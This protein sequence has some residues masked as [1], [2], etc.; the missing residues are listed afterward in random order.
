MAKDSCPAQYIISCSAPLVLLFS[1]IVL[2][3]FLSTRRADTTSRVLPDDAP[4]MASFAVER[5]PLP[6]D[7]VAEA[8]KV[9]TWLRSGAADFQIV[10]QIS[11]CKNVNGLFSATSRLSELFE[12][13]IKNHLPAGH[14]RP[15]QTRVIAIHFEKPTALPVDPGWVIEL[16]P[17]H[18]VQGPVEVGDQ[19]HTPKSYFHLTT[20][21]RVSG[22][23]FSI[24]LL[25]Q[26]P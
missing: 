6:P 17:V 18:V 5:R 23:F 2:I 7:A 9:A 13:E 4:R 12:D 1:T 3:S 16:L 19:Q 22:D 24:L 10:D 20:K 8:D 25:S 26:I 14:P 11:I 15:S 21:T